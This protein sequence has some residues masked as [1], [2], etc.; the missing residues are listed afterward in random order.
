MFQPLLDID[1]GADLGRWD[2]AAWGEILWPLIEMSVCELLEERAIAPAI[3]GIGGI[4]DTTS[5]A[6][7]EQYEEHPYPRWLELPRREPVGY[8]DYLTKRYPHFAP[9]AFL[10]GPVE[11]LA[12]GCGTG[13]EAVAIAAMR[14]RCRVLG[15]DL[16]R[17]SLAYAQRMASRLGVGAVR[18]VHGDILNA[19]RL[20]Q[21]FHVV[22]ST[23]VLHHMAEPMT[24]WRI[25]VDCLEARGLM[26]IG[27]YSAHARADVALARDEI[28]AASLAPVAADIRAFRERILAAAAGSALVGLAESEDLYTMSACRDLLFHAMEHRFTIPG[29]AAALDELGL[30]FIGFEPPVPGVLH[31]YRDFNPA[32]PG[33]TDLSGWARFEASRPELFS[34]LYVFWCQKRD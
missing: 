18:F 24:G 9:P 8:R 19:A 28:R 34:A 20:G 27:L 1:G 13:Q 26:K 33:M 25:L 10:D 4:D 21:R 15:L 3:P 17:R 11:V 22:E 23:G 32:D 29:I 7:R 12:A 2:R 30:D 31:D 5:T 16:S 14:T 6:V